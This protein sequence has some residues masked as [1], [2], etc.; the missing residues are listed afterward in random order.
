M[1]GWDVAHKALS[2]IEPYSAFLFG[3]LCL[4][5]ITKITD[6]SIKSLLVDLIS[7][8]SRVQKHP[9]SLR[10]CPKTSGGITKFSE[11]EAD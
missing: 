1:S 8:F 10:V 7:E 2:I 6:Q 3:L 4:Y 5:L 11:H 9:R